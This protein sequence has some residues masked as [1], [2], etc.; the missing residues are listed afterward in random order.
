MSPC[1]KSAAIK[2]CRIAANTKHSAR[3]NASDSVIII[4]KTVARM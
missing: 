2:A 1:I 3:A 4:N